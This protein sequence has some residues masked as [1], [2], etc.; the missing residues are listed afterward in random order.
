MVTIPTC[1]QK[2]KES[3]ENIKSSNAKRE[4]CVPKHHRQ[5]VYSVAASSDDDVCWSFA[6]GLTWVMIGFQL[7]LIR[8]RLPSLKYQQWCRYRPKIRL[9]NLPISSMSCN[10]QSLNIEPLPKAA[11]TARAKLRFR[12]SVLFWS[13]YFG[14]STVRVT[15]VKLKMTATTFTQLW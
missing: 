15:P 13:M 10:L 1:C 9:S 2:G 5:K 8:E 11:T 7:T 4:H 12:N 6:K 14:R 3:N